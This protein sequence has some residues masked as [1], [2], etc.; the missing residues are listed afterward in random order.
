MKA[1]IKYFNL[2]KCLFFTYYT[3]FE[4]KIEMMVLIIFIDL[5]VKC[6]SLQQ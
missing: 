6:T 2:L 3:Y 5:Y 1:Y 4:L